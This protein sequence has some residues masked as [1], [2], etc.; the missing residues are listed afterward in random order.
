MNF[1]T[2][3]ES[4]TDEEWEIAHAIA[5]T[6]SKDQIRIEVKSDGIVS[7]LKKVIAYLHNLTNRKDIT[8]KFFTYLKTLVE[9]GQN[10]GHSNQTPEY[11]RC[12]EKACRK[13]LQDY[14]ADA[15]TLLKILGWSSR[16]IRY[17]KVAPV[18]E[19]PITLLKKC[20]FQIADVLE[21]KV[22]KKT[23]K[24][25]KVTYEV[26]EEQYNEKEPKS[27]AMIPENEVVKVQ[28]ISLK[29]D[30]SINHVKFIKQ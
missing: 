4:L 9:K 24:G 26:R 28:I 14:Q 23:N 8:D 19:L 12:I 15:Q 13:Y 20:Q 22:I 3:L 7:E 1:S 18:A 29:L 11:Y 10:I 6:L 27:F 30:G 2:Q 17:Y 25:S 5:H 21:A 16:L